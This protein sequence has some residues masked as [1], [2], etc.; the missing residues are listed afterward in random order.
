[1]TFSYTTSGGVCAVKIIV[2][3][4]EDHIIQ[5]VVFQ[6]GCPGNHLGIAALV[7]GMA[8]RDV[9]A[10]LNGIRCGSRSSSCPDQL[11]KALDAYCREYNIG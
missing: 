8:P 5:E 11:A 9:I 7:K 1:M 6:G 3:T 4:D 2:E 10:R